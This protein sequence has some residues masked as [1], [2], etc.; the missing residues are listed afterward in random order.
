M[1]PGSEP[2]IQAI[3]LVQTLGPADADLGEAE[4]FGLLA[5]WGK[6]VTSDE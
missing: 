4:L 2:L 6:P 5:K 1:M 3:A